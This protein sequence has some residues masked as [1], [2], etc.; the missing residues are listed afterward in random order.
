MKSMTKL[1]IGAFAL[2]ATVAFAET[3]STDPT[4]IARQDLMKIIGKNTK[5]LGDMAGGKA[6]FDAAAAEAAKVAL[7]AASAEISAKFEP[8]V[9]DAGSEAKPEV[10][11]NWEDFAAKGK[12]L[13]A[14]A[15]ALDTATVESVGAGM[16]AVGGSCG[17]CHKAYRM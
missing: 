16:G 2:V 11:T 9:T 7:V 10:W 17:A 3:E 6:A 4:V 15:T 12:A 5:V 1:L 8:N 14:A 13:N